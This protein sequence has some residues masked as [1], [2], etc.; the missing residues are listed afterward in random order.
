MVS[1]EKPF[2]VAFRDRAA[3]AETSYQKLRVLW[4]SSLSGRSKLHIF[5]SVF[6]STL[7][8]GLETL[9]LQ[10]KFLWKVEAY[11]IRFL[12]SIVG[13]K[14]SFYSCVTYSMA[15]GRVSA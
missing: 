13:I 14:A 10:E 3:I 9:M 8:Y 11:Y 5:Q 1:W 4:N 7:T 15:E 12:R 6:L 2:E